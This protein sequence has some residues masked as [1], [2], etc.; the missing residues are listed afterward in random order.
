MANHCDDCDFCGED[1]RLT[2][3]GE[4]CCQKAIDAEKIRQ[5]MIKERLEAEAAILRQ[6]G[7][8]VEVVKTYGYGGW[9]ISGMKYVNIADVLRPLGDKISNLVS[10]I[11]DMV[12]HDGRTGTY[13][14]QKV[15]EEFDI[16]R[17]A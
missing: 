9:E 1:R 10:A 4:T 16:L 17:G 13:S 15:L 8:K 11:N 12:E 14:Y 7:F 5:D 3:R 2:G 6:F